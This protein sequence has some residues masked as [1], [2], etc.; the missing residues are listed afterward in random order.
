MVVVSVLVSGLIGAFNGGRLL[1]LL[2][3]LFCKETRKEFLNIYRL[4]SI[5]VV[6]IICK[7][8][9]FQLLVR[10][11]LLGFEDP[12][13]PPALFS[14]KKVPRQSLWCQSFAKCLHLEPSCFR[15]I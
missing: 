3:L 7:K 2:L 4:A 9:Q 10:L 6:S 11:M 5:F 14:L 15:L 1:L 13:E 12:Q 8:F